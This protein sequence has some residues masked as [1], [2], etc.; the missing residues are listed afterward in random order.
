MMGEWGDLIVTNK[1]NKPRTPIDVEKTIHPLQSAETIMSLNRRDNDSRPTKIAKPAAI[2]GKLKITGVLKRS[3][4]AQN[5]A[6]EILMNCLI[7]TM[8]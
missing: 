4:F 2:I 7:I 3:K 6:M 8:K 1:S 5:T